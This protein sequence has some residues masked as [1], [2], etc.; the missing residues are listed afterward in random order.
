MHACTAPDIQNSCDG[1]DSVARHAMNA[2]ASHHSGLT[3]QHLHRLDLLLKQVGP[4]NEHQV[5]KSSEKQCC[6]W[7]TK[8]FVCRVYAVMAGT[9]STAAVREGSVVALAE[10]KTTLL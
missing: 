5:A 9:K 2:Q 7:L 3:L 1:I 10:F 4:A 8:C 6:T